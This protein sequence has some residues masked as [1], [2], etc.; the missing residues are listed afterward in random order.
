MPKYLLIVGDQNG[1]AR[2]EFEVL[3]ADD[4]IEARQHALSWLDTLP[5]RIGLR[6][7]IVRTPDWV[8]VEEHGKPNA[9][10]EPHACN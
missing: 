6:V 1:N 7:W 9:I 10:C 8:I 2:D 5:D 4:L 3:G